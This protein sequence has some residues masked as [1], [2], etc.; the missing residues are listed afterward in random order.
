MPPDI[1]AP[2]GE[3][4]YS[5]FDEYRRTCADGKVP[6]SL[7]IEKVDEWHAKWNAARVKPR[8]PKAKKEPSS[9]AER[10]Y[11]LYPRKVGRPVA[12]RAISKALA[13][14]SFDILKTRVQVFSSYVERWPDSDKPHSIPHPTTFFNQERYEDAPETYVRPNMKPLPPPPKPESLEP[15]GWAE[16]MKANHPHW[17]EFQDPRPLTWARLPHLSRATVLDAM[18]RK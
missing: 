8:K 10:I 17:R 5:C 12:L 9:D 16:Y 3:F 18:K 13:K 2:F 11:E 1:R 15:S 4:L 6:R 14:L 7:W